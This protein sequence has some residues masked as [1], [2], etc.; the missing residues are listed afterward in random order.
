MKTK[1]ILA[2]AILTLFLVVYLPANAQKK[3]EDYKLYTTVQIKPMKGKAKEFEK[4]TLAHIEK[5]HKE[6]I[7]KGGLRQIL[8]GSKS[9]SYVWVGGPNMFS[10]FDNIEN[11]EAHDKDWAH[12]LENYVKYIGHLEHWKMNDKLSFTG[13]DAE[14]NKFFQIWI[15]DVAKGE[16]ETFNKA[17]GSAVEVNKEQGNTIHSYNNSFNEGNGRDVALT[18]G[19]EKWAELDE[20]DPFKDHYEAKHGEGSWEKFIENWQKSTK[21]INQAVWRIVK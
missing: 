6:G 14:T 17:L 10:D 2:V 12:I 7:R 9:G 15:I 21:K 20:D 8:T 19:F 1:N 4:A 11:D 13:P 16:W 18:F 5:F 3:V